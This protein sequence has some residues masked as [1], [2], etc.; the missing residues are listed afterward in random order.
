M[1]SSPTAAARGPGLTSLEEVFLNI[2]R[3]AEVEAAA[4]SGAADVVHALDD[5]SRLVIPVGAELVQHP[6]TGVAY[7]VRWG[8]DEAGRLVIS[9]CSLAGRGRAT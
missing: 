9:D 6:G 1:P 4:V 7:K 2:A 3:R 8:T 5:G